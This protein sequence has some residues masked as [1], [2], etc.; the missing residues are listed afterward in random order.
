MLGRLGWLTLW[1]VACTGPTD[2]DLPD[3]EV[4]EED[5]D[6]DNLDDSGTLE[7][8]PEGPDFFEPAFLIVEAEFGWDSTTR[9][10]VDVGSPYG[11]F[12]PIIR[13]MHGSAEWQAD[14]FDFGSEFYCEAQLFITQSTMSTRFAA[15]P[16]AWL[17]FDY[18]TADG[19][20]TDCNLGD[21]VY[22]FDPAVW[23]EDPIGA[24]AAAEWGVGVGE[25]VPAVYS[26]WV[27]GGYETNVFG[28][29]I[30]NSALPYGH[31]EYAAFNREIDASFSVI[32][33]EDL[34]Y[35]L[36]P[37]TSINLGD[38]NIATGWYLIIG[39]GVWTIQ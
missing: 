8:V 23:G 12:A 1:A 10:L 14:E 36:L 30:L 33:D 38:N 6:T 7:S 34:N 26:G 19:I 13:I 3:T 9:Q 21:G 22:D 17:G 35:T 11:T 31:N 2:K 4:P 27:G 32:L 15:D 37:N 18:N 29:I 16:N 5:D 24:L 25:I 39:G 28:G 20:A